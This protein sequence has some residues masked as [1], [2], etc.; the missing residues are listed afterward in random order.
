MEQSVKR[1][2]PALIVLCLL[3]DFGLTLI[4]AGNLIL[5]KPLGWFLSNFIDLD[6]E[7]NLPSWYSSMKLF[8]AGILLISL[9]KKLD[10]GRARL[11][12]LLSL[13]GLVFL[14]MSLD[15]ISSIHEWLGQSSD[16]LL[17][18]GQRNE[19]FFVRTGIWMFL[20]G[21]PVFV[22]M[23]ILLKHIGREL[24]HSKLGWRLSIGMII[25]LASATGTEILSNFMQTGGAYILQVC[26]EEF[27]EM[28]GVTIIL[29]AIYD[30]NEEFNLGSLSRR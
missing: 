1:N 7:A 29:W 8:L 2:I 28:I 24:N 23:L 6:R 25:F 11:R 30:M 3:M 26:A 14:A 15:E 22:F 4:Y 21:L 10:T 20:I 5:D 12:W 19:T 9:V 17:P 16:V 27:G 13:L 18:G